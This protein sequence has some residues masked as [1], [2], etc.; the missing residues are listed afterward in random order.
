MIK[1]LHPVGP[2]ARSLDRLVASYRDLFLGEVVRTFG[3]SAGEEEFDARL[4]MKRSAGRLVMLRLGAASIAIIEF[5]GPAIIH[6]DSDRS[7]ANPGFSHFCMAVEDRVSEYRKKSSPC[8]M[9]TFPP[10][11]GT[12][13][14]GL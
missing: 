1:G 7:V 12:H 5:S 6:A 10:A 14:N 9:R 4:G 13:A 11:N 8:R 3:W 2:T